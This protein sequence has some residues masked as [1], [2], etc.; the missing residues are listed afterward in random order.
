[1]KLICRQ[2]QVRLPRAAQF[3]ESGEDE[4]DRLLEP[5]VRIEARKQKLREAKCH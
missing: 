4:M 3:A 5:Q 1:M 2:G